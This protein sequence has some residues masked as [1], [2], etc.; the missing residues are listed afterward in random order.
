LLQDGDVGVGK[1]VHL[2]GPKFMFAH[3]RRDQRKSEKRT[4]SLD[5]VRRIMATRFPSGD[6]AKLTTELGKC[7]N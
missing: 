5:S 2:S 1:M 3:E 4:R 7:V 6:H